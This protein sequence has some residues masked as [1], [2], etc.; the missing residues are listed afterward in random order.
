MS[1]PTT[2][3]PARVVA[4]LWQRAGLAVLVCS[5][6]AGVLVLGPSWYMLEVYD[7]VVG[8]RS[9]STLLM[10]SLAVVLLIGLLE[11]IE[12]HRAEVLR[13][14]ARALDDALASPVAA[15]AFERVHQRGPAAGQQALAALQSLRHFVVS[16]ALTGLLDAPM[17]IVYLALLWLLHPV[18]SAVALGAALLQAASAWWQERR[19]A[20]PLQRGNQFSTSAAAA[21]QQAFDQVPAWLA[22]GMREAM[23]QRWGQL[24]QQ[25]AER[26]SAVARHQAGHQA[27]S[28][29]V[30][31]AVGSAL[32][33]GACWL[34]LE[35]ALPGGAGMMI[36]ASVLGGRVV[37]P[38]VQLVAHGALLGQA[39]EAW[40]TLGELLPGQED[41]SPP[42]SLPPPKGQLAVDQLT[43]VPTA[44][45]GGQRAPLLRGVQFSLAPGELLVVLGPSGAGKSTLAR[46]LVGLQAAAAGSV[47]LDGVDVSIWPRE[48]LGPQIGYLPQQVALLDGSLVDN[49]SRFAEPDPVLLQQALGDAGLSAF[50]QSLPMGLMTDLGE[51]GVWLSGGWRQRVGLARALYGRPAYVVLD[52][53]NASLDREGEAALEHALRACKARGSTVIVMSHRASVVALADRLL[54]LREGQQLA[55][56]PRDEVMTALRKA[57][58]AAG[59][60]PRAAHAATPAPTTARLAAPAALST[61]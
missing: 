36:M 7:R 33:G 59:S 28:R 16:P 54:V 15:S 55:F 25:A 1:E 3:T 34:L 58:P 44:A 45:L 11:L 51:G 29:W 14:A 35:Q 48:A 41:Q 21:A 31:Q 38:L 39:R 2:I 18:L 43:V 57:G 32:L 22:L 49:V 37:A 4:H 56:G 61:P 30:Q 60:A 20:E 8:S 9:I 24:Q 52:E 13:E 42:M 40:R 5:V 12:W 27:F 17:A 46:A 47:R 6:L 23:A 19:N 26:L 53:P 50:V 10:L